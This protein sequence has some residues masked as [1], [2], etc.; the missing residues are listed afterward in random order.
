MQ[1]FF[2]IIALLLM[3][4]TSAL[5]VTIVPPDP[6]VEKC[7]HLSPTAE[8]EATPPETFN[9]TNNLRRKTGT[10]L[11][12]R[13]TPII[14]NGKLLDNKC[15]PIS[16]ARIEVWQ[17]ASPAAKGKITPKNDP[18]FVGSATTFSNNLGQFTFLSVLPPASST[19]ML[20]VKIIRDTLPAFKTV[21]YVG[22]NANLKRKNISERAMLTAQPDKESSAASAYGIPYYITFT[23]KEDEQYRRY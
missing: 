9:P 17:N 18:D 7:G 20:H 8:E 1:I 5:A 19:T 3:G 22:N 23:L 15:I 21:I 13:G 11:T 14:I 10:L 16:D 2:L 6:V 4:S 12:A